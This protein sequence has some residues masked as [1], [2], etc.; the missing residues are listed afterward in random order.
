ML[1]SFPTI[2]RHLMAPAQPMFSDLEA[3]S[4]R[5]ACRRRFLTL[6]DSKIPRGAWA[7]RVEPRCP[8]AGVC[9]VKSN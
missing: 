6:L 9:F 5:A 3:S 2:R 4:G 1:P 7:A 8:K